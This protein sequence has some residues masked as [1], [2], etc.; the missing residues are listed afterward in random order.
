[1]RFTDTDAMASNDI[2]FLTWNKD[3]SVKELLQ[4]RNENFYHNGGKGAVYNPKEGN[5]ALNKLLKA[6][7]TIKNQVIKYWKINCIL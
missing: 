6:Y 1:M 5:I 7:Q 2:I 3:N 4:Y